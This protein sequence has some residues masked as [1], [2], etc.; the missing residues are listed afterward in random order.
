MDSVEWT[1]RG[2]AG[3]GWAGVDSEY[4]TGVDW[5]GPHILTSPL[6]QTLHSR[7]SSH[8]PY[9][10]T[11]LYILYTTHSITLVKESYI[12]KERRK[13]MEEEYKDITS[14]L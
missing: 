11:G 10:H 3:L 14:I 2:W 12:E 4:L 5:A 13:G 7:F 8:T 9:S 6:T 1:R